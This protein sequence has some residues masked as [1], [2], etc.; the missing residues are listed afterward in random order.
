MS[1]PEVTEHEVAAARR[2]FAEELRHVARVQSPAVVHAFATVP[3]EHFAGPG[4][5]RLLSPW[6]LQGYWT[7]EDADPRHLYHDVLIAIDEARRLNNGQPSLWAFL[8]D[9]LGLAAGEHVVHIG[10]GTGY[11]TAILADIVGRTGTVTAVEIDPTLAERARMNLAPAWPQANV[12]TADGFAFRPGRPADVII[13][14]AGVTHLPL[15]WLDS[16]AEDNG[17][18][19]VPLTEAGRAGVFILI[20]RRNGERQRYAA[21][22]VCRV[23]II[24]CVGGRDDEAEARLVAAL[25]KSR[26]APPIQSLRRA[27][28]EPDETCWLAGDGWWL[29]TAPLEA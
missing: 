18:L 19:L 22:Y 27:P 20:T 8:Y 16:L 4:P 17:R 28:D 12:V 29:S 24:D 15:A 21:R 10:V 3:R 14:N 13:V 2:W 7:T 11:Y 1:R 5:W 25:R 23:G 26:S 9:H 6:Y